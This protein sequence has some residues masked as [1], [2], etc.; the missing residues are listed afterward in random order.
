MGSDQISAELDA[1]VASR[2]V[3]RRR[4]ASGGPITP[5]HSR[6]DALPPVASPDSPGSE[7]HQRNLQHFQKARQRFARHGQVSAFEEHPAAAQDRS[8]DEKVYTA[9][10]PF[11]SKRMNF[12]GGKLHQ[13]G[14]D[15]AQRPSTVG[16]DKRA[17]SRVLGYDSPSMESF[18][19]SANL[20]RSSPS[21]A[22]DP[23]RAT[24]LATEG[25]TAPASHATADYSFDPASHQ[26]ARQPLALAGGPLPSRDGE[27]RPPASKSAGELRAQSSRGQ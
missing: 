2:H 20:S 27:H 22:S 23:G 26:V 21:Q 5:K 14:G 15:S 12:V 25:L 6:N 3:A 13:K 17:L 24:S 11:L 18:D 9:P 4:K 10:S 19:D 8:R 16:V 7:D 1:L